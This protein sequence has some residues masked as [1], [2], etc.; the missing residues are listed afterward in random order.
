M[1]EAI[2]MIEAQEQLKKLNTLDWPNLKNDKRQ[3]EHRRL[4]KIA[5]PSSI[6]EK[7]YITIDD[8]KSLQGG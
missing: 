1:W 7:N 4:N 3:K 8:L 2:T 6:K 5:Y